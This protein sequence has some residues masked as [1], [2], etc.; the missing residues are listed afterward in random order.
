M[1]TVVIDPPEDQWYRVVLTRTGSS[2]SAT[3]YDS[4]GA[5]LAS[6]TATDSAH[7]TS[8]R[9][10]VH[11]GYTY[12]VDDITVTSAGAPATTVAVD[13][14][15]NLN[16]TYYFSPSLGQPSL[17]AGETDTS[18]AFNGTNAVAIGDSTLLNTSTRS[19]RSAELWF[20]ADTTT[21]RQVLYEEGGST[22]GMVIYLEDTGL[23]ARAWSDSTGWTNELDTAVRVAAGTTYH[24]VVTLDTDNSPNLTLYLNGSPVATASKPDTQPW[25]THSDDGAIAVQNGST[26]YHDGTFGAIGTNYFQGT[27][28]DVSIYNTVLS[29]SRVQARWIAGGP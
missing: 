29:A 7:A 17:I 27:V 3:L 10:V 25:S 4:V 6:T 22:N 24:V 5:V 1:S 19:E 18:T 13:S 16:G 9:I 14:R 20:R 15:G 2:F 21:G 8:D 12:Y 26:R 11:G 23:R 28:D